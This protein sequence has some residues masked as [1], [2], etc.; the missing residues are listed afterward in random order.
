M[1]LRNR[2]VNT[3]GGVLGDEKKEGVRGMMWNGC[4]RNKKNRGVGGG[5]GGGV[6]LIIIVFI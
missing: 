6:K 4:W 3:A 2:R 5:G 1:I